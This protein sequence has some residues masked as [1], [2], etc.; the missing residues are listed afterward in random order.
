[1]P[2]GSVNAIVVVMVTLASQ[3][4]LAHT[5]LHWYVLRNFNEFIFINKISTI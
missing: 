2:Q 1:M 4:P 5:W 3:Q